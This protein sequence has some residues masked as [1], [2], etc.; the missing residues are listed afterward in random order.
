[1][2]SKK[3][4][5]VKKRIIKL[6]KVRRAKN[7][8]QKGKKKKKRNNLKKQTVKKVKSLLRLG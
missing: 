8:D 6:T 5:C 2:A 3:K 1:M 4:N 7:P